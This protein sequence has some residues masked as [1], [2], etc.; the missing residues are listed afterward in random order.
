MHLDLTLFDVLKN[1]DSVQ[2]KFI[3]EKPVTPC[4]AC[5]QVMSDFE[6]RQNT[7]IRVL[8]YCSGKNILIARGLNS[9]LPFQFVENRLSK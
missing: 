4:G 1:H 6:Q 8:M 3:I 2:N 9:F 5:L 7:P